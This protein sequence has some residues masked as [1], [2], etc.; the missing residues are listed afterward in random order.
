M[1]IR[2]GIQQALDALHV[3]HGQPFAVLFVLQELQRLGEIGLYLPEH[4]D[5][6]G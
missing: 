5:P 2:G 3:V 4:L 1:A 6:V